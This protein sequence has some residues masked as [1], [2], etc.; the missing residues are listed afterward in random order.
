MLDSKLSV[1]GTERMIRVQEEVAIAHSWKA[2][3][4]QCAEFNG[5]A[6]DSAHNN[7]FVFQL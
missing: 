4:L 6:T 3:I 1:Y 7:H 2:I 5:F